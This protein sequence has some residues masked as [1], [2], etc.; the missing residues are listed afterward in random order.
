MHEI[1]I[2]F[3]LHF[4]FSVTVYKILNFSIL[5]FSVSCRTL[6]IE[7]FS[8]QIRCV[9]AA[10]VTML[11]NMLKFGVPLASFDFHRINTNIKY[12]NLHLRRLPR[13]S[14]PLPP[15]TPVMTVPSPLAK[16][17]PT[18][19]CTSQFKVMDRLLASKNSISEYFRQHLQNARK[20]TSHEWTVTN[21]VY[22]LLH[23]VSEATIRMQGAGDTHVSQAMFI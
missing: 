1:Y 19:R 3:I 5:Y 18:R 2:Y 7:S 10:F 20:L 13:R 9:S 14:S 21:E 4:V 16:H 8:L 23:D 6:E 12:K 17:D 22:S 11:N 15:S